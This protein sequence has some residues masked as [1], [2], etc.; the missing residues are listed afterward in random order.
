MSAR[1][2][3]A[4]V[5]AGGPACTPAPLSSSSCCV[6]GAGLSPPGS[7]GNGLSSRDIEEEVRLPRS[8]CGPG[9]RVLSSFSSSLTPPAGSEKFR[10]IEMTGS[11]EKAV[12][13]P[14]E[15]N[16]LAMFGSHANDVRVGVSLLMEP[17]RSLPREAVANALQVKD[18]SAPRTGVEVCAG[19]GEAPIDMDMDLPW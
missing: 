11:A 4:V 19:C 18:E 2:R 8:R 12:F 15:G 16:D 10:C 5:N 17:L 3:L 13:R 14:R 7:N 9:R 1:G 6:E